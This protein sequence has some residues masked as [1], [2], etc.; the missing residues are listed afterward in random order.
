MKMYKIII[1]LIFLSVIFQ[2]CESENEN[3]KSNKGDDSSLP[4]SSGSIGEILLV[5]DTS[6]LHLE[7]GQT[8]K[9]VFLEPFPGLP[10]L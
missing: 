6:H 5:V 8:L 4:A 3:M 1:G 7:L 2:S 9:D 10:K